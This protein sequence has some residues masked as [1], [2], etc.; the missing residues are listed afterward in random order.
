MQQC[1]DRRKYNKYAQEIIQEIMVLHKL[2]MPSRKIS[3]TLFGTESKK[4]TINNVLNRG[5]NGVSKGSYELRKNSPRIL[6]IDFETLPSTAVVFGRFNLNLSP[7]HIIEEGNQILSASWCFLDDEDVTGIVM[8]K[9]EVKVR[10]DSRV[11]ACVYEVLQ[12]ADIVVAQNGDKFDIP[13]FKTRCIVNN[14]PPIK[15]FKTIDTLKIAKQLKFDS[16][17]LDSVASAL[18]LGSKMSHTGIKLWIDCMN[19]DLKALQEMLQYNR[20][21]V[22]LLREV[23][24]KLRPYDNRH[25]NISLYY[26]GNEV[27]CPVCGSEDIHPTGNSVFTSVSEF[28]EVACNDCGHRSRTRNNI[29]SKDKR[30]N[31]L[32][33]F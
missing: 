29:N 19:G 13:L 21:D 8:T 3:Q 9:E 15:R 2:G 11:V 4:S 10:D 26:T 18:G 31:T 28:Q 25:P 30:K 6:F 24:L 16:N 22:R 33:V 20:Q 5:V 14:F 7:K 23:Y 27:R 1:T 17:S 12:S 32:M